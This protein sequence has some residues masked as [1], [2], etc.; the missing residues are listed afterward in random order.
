M[1]DEQV[2]EKSVS[3]QLY[4]SLRSA[5]D[6]L[7]PRYT[8]R[9]WWEC[10]MWRLLPSGFTAEY[11]IKLTVSDFRADA[12]K[13]K[14][15]RMIFDP[16]LRKWNDV[17]SANKHELLAANTVGPNR[18]YYVIPVQM[19]NLVEIPEWAGLLLFDG[20]RYPFMQKEAPKRHKEKWQGSRAKLLE[21]FYHRYWTHETKL[22]GSGEMPPIIESE[23]A[24]LSPTEQPKGH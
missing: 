13:E 15:E 21:T 10:D 20:H 17:G 14:R 6:L 5:S 2:N 1:S 8:P 4:W 3:I 16:E 12:K 19:E 23:L 24:E 7:I 9:D 18:F 22:K 11:E